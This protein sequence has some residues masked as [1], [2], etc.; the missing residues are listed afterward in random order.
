MHR[1]QDLWGTDAEEFGPERWEDGRQRGWQFL[2]FNGGPRVYLGQKLAMTKVAFVRVRLVQTMKSVQ[3]RDARSWREELNLAL[4][5]GGEV[6][7]KGGKCFDL[8]DTWGVF[9]RL[10]WG[11]VLEDYRV[12]RMDIEGVCTVLQKPTTVIRQTIIIAIYKRPA[13]IVLGYQKLTVSK[14]SF[15][16]TN[17][18]KTKTNSQLPLFQY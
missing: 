17:K 10:K 3:S 1:R 4:C 12:Q 14:H 5:S 11:R 8:G 18:T 13:V 9:V 16:S 7:V 6:R 2:S 15:L